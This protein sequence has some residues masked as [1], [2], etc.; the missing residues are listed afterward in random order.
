MPHY[1]QTTEA[2]S[3]RTNGTDSSDLRRK[4]PQWYED[5]EEVR[6][7]SSPDNYRRKSPE[8]DIRR[9]SADRRTPDKYDRRSPEYRSPEKY[10]KRSADRYRGGTPDEYDRMPETHD[11]DRNSFDNNGKRSPERRYSERRSPDRRSPERRS[12]ERWSPERRSPER[13]SPERGS[14]ERWSLERRSP[15]RR[16]PERRSPERRSPERRSPERRSP[17]RGSP[18]RRSPEKRS[19]KRR[20]PERRSPERRSPE[21]RSADTHRRRQDDR[22][23]RPESEKKISDYGRRSSTESFQT[24]KIKKSDLDE[25]RRKYDL[26]F[27]E[28]NQNTISEDTGNRQSESRDNSNIYKYSSNMTNSSDSGRSNTTRSSSADNVRSKGQSSHRRSKPRKKAEWRVSFKIFKCIF[29]DS[30]VQNPDPPDSGTQSKLSPHERY[31]R[32]KSYDAHESRV[33]SPMPDFSHIRSSG[34]GAG[35]PSR[36]R[37]ESRDPSYRGQGRG[38]RVLPDV[39]T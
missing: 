36:E 9:R 19:P 10:H 33:A 1:M 8:N 2:F 18:D 5:R 27:K 6:D 24:V 30:C 26:R 21:R 7:R 37:S 29:L 4:Y 28:K 15:E 13:R 25:I 39:D 34:Y 14:P 23:G 11:Q 31:S 16:S 12:P 17:E 22:Y 38:F 35:A 20:S 3:R 32:R